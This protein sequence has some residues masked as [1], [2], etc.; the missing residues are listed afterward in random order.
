MGLISD[1][2]EIVKKDK[3]L[4]L[5][6]NVFMF[7][8]FLLGMIVGT[9]FP[10]IHDALENLIG[11]TLQSGTLSPIVETVQSGDI[12]LGALFIFAWNYFVATI[13]TASL[14]SLVFPPWILIKFGASSFVA[15]IVFAGRGGVTVG[16][17]V[18]TIGTLL[19]EFEGY[20]VAIFASMRLLEAAIWPQRF[21]ETSRPKAYVK[22]IVDN[23]KLLLAAGAILLV[24]ALY[25]AAAIILLR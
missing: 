2:I 10:G 11:Q 24:A 19:L 23:A 4:F 3:E 25:E 15:G 20:V 14:P 7:G 8:F 17:L 6:S 1:I 13:L 5:A 18:G 21:G 16:W 22:A 12:V 9:A